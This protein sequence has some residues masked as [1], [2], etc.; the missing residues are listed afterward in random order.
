MNA[1]TFDVQKM[2]VK[3]KTVAFGNFVDP[4]RK[5]VDLPNLVLVAVE[6]PEYSR[7]GLGKMLAKTVRY[8]F[9]DLDGQFGC[10][11]MSVGA[12]SSRAHMLYEDMNPVVLG[13]FEEVTSKAPAIAKILYARHFAPEIVALGVYAGTEMGIDPE[14]PEDV[15]KLISFVNKYYRRA[16]YMEAHPMEVRMSNIEALVGESK[17]FDWTRIFPDIETGEL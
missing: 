17:P 11:G 7:N 14:K 5:L 16:S 10:E 1:T 4:E 12:E 2:A 3:A 15:A 13:T 8:E 9:T 6:L